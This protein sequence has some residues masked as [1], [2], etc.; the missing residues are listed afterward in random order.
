MRSHWVGFVLGI[1][2]YALA[3]FILGKTSG[4][5]D[6]RKE[7]VYCRLRVVGE[8]R[9]WLASACHWRVLDAGAITLRPGFS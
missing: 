8:R 7:K 3:A 1:G 2:R 5:E 6:G 4:G 9:G